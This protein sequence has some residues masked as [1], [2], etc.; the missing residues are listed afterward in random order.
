MHLTI[1]CHVIIYK[2]SGIRI[3]T[4]AAGTL[5]VPKWILAW[6][7]CVFGLE[8]SD[9]HINSTVLIYFCTTHAVRA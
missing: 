4:V 5:L 1:H 7:A 9:I 8:C 6:S 3:K 2:L